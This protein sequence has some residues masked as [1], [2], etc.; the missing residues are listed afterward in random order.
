M[1][2]VTTIPMRATLKIAGKA[3]LEAFEQ[4]GQRCADRPARLNLGLFRPYLVTHPDQ[5]RQVLRGGETYVRE[6]MIW[7][8]LRRLEGHGIA[9]EG[10]RWRT[11]RRILQPQFTARHVASLSSLMAE[12]ACESFDLL[13]TEAPGPVD[14]PLAMTRFTHRVLTRVFF[15]DRITL[16]ECDR[17]GE[18]IGTAFRSIG[19]RIVM[20]FLSNAVPVPGD[21]TFRRAVR[22]V[23]EIIQ[24]LIAQSRAAGGDDL[25]T[26]LL[27]AT[28]DNGQRLS[29]RAVRDDVVAMYIAGTETTAL[30]LTWLWLL[31]DAHPEVGERLTAEV[32]QV[33]GD[34]PPRAEHLS[35]LTYTRMV[36]HEV[37]RLYPIGWMVPRTVARPDTLGGVELRPGDTVLLSPYLTHRLPE[38]WPDPRTFRPE[39][40][41]PGREA[42]RHRFA[43]VPFGGGPHQCLG[44]H[45]ALRESELAVAGMLSRFR[46]EVVHPQSLEAKVSLVLEP[47]QRPRLRL[48]PRGS[49][50]G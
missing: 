2:T 27:H 34:G 35:E 4:I 33:V 9:G 39:R 11:S 50:L 44:N 12:A 29:D 23:D 26:L 37:L 49:L 18:A 41:A 30:T 22:T 20:P 17:L 38:Y 16:A 36:I 8:P 7:Q 45:F 32:H 25:I 3:G 21:R 24:P 42:G 28:D 48:H 14:L 13:A 40:F 43:Y 5:V 19:L 46:P 6:G 47:R 1:S 10:P 15:N 31:V